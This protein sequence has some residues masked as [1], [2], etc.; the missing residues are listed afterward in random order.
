MPDNCT[1][2]GVELTERSHDLPTFRHPR[3]A[4]YVLGPEDGSLSRS[5]Q[6]K[7]A[8][9][10]RIPTKFCINI[11]LAAA[12]VMYDRTLNL[13]GWSTRPMLPGGPV[14]DPQQIWTSVSSRHGE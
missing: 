10:V 12:L 3:N 7:C 4:A 2:V 5:M 11:S 9:M 6:G 1:L 14:L 13:G 8:H